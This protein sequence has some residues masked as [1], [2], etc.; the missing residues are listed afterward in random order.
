MV[1]EKP[2]EWSPEWKEESLTLG[3]SS[4][5]KEKG[6]DYLSRTKQISVGSGSLV[7]KSDRQG[8]WL[9][10]PH[11]ATASFRVSMA[12]NSFMSDATLT[13]TITATKG[14]IGGFLIGATSLT[15]G[16]LTLDSSGV[17]TLGSGTDHIRLSGASRTV[18]HRIGAKNRIILGGENPDLIWYDSNGDQAA[19]FT[20]TGVDRLELFVGDSNQFSLDF[21][22]LATGTAVV[23]PNETGWNLGTSTKYFN[24]V[25]YVTL[26]SHT[27][28]VIDKGIEKIR[29]IQRDKDGKIEKGLLDSHLTDGRGG[30][31]TD[32]LIMALV[33]SVKKLDERLINLGG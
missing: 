22:M 7:F 15:G 16:S 6:F 32:N 13:G 21:A 19:K 25:H 33:D 27:P 4:E 17:I 10:S 26:I 8:I 29:T 28:E 12:G 9:G 18:T 24:Q 2:K 14:N 30:L 1:E 11:F 5:T 23:R 31:Y 20:N 3:D